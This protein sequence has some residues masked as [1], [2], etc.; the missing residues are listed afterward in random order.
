MEEKTIIPKFE[1]PF[2][3]PIGERTLIMSELRIQKTFN[4]PYL[5]MFTCK[6]DTSNE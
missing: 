6:E 1:F 2:S 4:V 3:N 5:Q